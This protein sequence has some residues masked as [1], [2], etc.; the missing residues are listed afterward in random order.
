MRGFAIYQ[1]L[2]LNRIDAMLSA[3]ESAVQPLD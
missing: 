2:R 1:P 3:T